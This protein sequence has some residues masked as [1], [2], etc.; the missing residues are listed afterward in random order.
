VTVRRS[1]QRPNANWATSSLFPATQPVADGALDLD[2]VIDFLLEREILD[3]DSVLAGV[4]A[5]PV[6]RRNSN[7][8]VTLSDGSGVFVKQAD[9]QA[10][11]SSRTVRAEGEFYLEWK[12]SSEAGKLSLPRLLHF[13]P[14]RPLVVLELLS[15]HQPILEYSRAFPTDHF[16]IH[17]WRVL[18]RYLGTIHQVLGGAGHDTVAP[19]GPL[20]WVVRTA[21][22]YI[23][24]LATLSGAALGVIE[25]LQGSEVLIDGLHSIRRLWRDQQLIHGDVR[26]DNIL[27]RRDSDAEFDVRLVD[28][29]MHR[30]GDPLWDVAG[31]LNVLL[32]ECLYASCVEEV[33]PDSDSPV[34]W[35]VFQSASRALWE[36]YVATA[37]QRVGGP[38][39]TVETLAV[40]CAARLVETAVES[41]GRADHVP[42]VLVVAL[43]AAENMF[44]DRAHAAIRFFGID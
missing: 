36:G 30:R 41:T 9:S 20:P 12:A 26:A 29:E 25:I 35:V 24:S 32:L 4:V 16:P 8:R 44:A 23:Q 21:R 34:P 18:G 38:Q 17:A 3:P 43:Q 15:R 37:G 31:A 39:L 13:D 22:P 40:Y 14:H 2:T 5:D 19:H 27:V 6:P 1:W 10:E 42:D 11:G 28:W 7:L 33:A